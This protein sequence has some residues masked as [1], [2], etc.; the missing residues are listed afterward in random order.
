LAF[1]AGF[2]TFPHVIGFLKFVGILNAAA[3][4]GATIYQLFAVSPVLRSA[5]VEQVLTTRH[6]PYVSGVI[7]QIVADRFFYWLLACGLLGLAHLVAERFYFGK[8]AQRLGFGLVLG[9]LAATLCLGLI[10]QPKVRYW[11]LRSHAVN[12]TPP[13]RAASLK[14]VRAWNAFAWTLHLALIGGLGVHL[15]RMSNPPEQ[16]RFLSPSQ[17]RY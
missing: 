12:Y 8:T 11:H 16:K 2:P 14:M 10:V 3:W 15:W 1:S 17:F 9:L 6:F 13:Q 5:G 4:L 7:A